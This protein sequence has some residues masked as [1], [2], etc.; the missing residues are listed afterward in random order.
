VQD[1]KDAHRIFVGKPLGKRSCVFGRQDV[2]RT[3][4]KHN[5]CAILGYY[6]ANCADYHYLLLFHGGSLQSRIV[7]NHFCSKLSLLAFNL[8]AVL[9]QCQLTTLLVITV[10]HCFKMFLYRKPSPLSNIVNCFFSF[11][12]F[13]P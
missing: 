13:L 7:H 8:P 11:P 3:V 5:N 6:T 1:D 12:V 9:P 4:H 10:P 2:G